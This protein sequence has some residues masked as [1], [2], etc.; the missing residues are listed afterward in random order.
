ML[1]INI[2]QNLFPS[3]HNDE[4]LLIFY[5]FIAKLS[6]ISIHVEFWLSIFGGILTI[7]HFLVL[8]RKAMKSTSII[9]L[10]ISVAICDFLSMIVSISSKDMILNF[11]GSDCTPPNSFLTFQIFWVLMSIRD[12]VVRC[13]TWLTVL[14]ALIRFLVSKYASEVR[15][16]KMSMF[17]FGFKSSA[18]SVFISSL[19]SSCFYLC[20]KFVEI[21]TWTPANC[22]TNIPLDSQ[23]PLY[24][25]RVS[26]L[27]SLYDGAPVQIFQFINGIF[28]KLI[29]CIILPLLT[30]LLVV[31]LKR[32]E[33]SRIS[34]SVL[35]KNN[36]EKTTNLVIIMTFSIFLAS[37][38]T[39]IATVF[40]V[41]YSDLGFLFIYINVD[42]ICDTLLLWNASTN[43][44]ICF[45]MSSQYRNTAK[46]LLKIKVHVNNNHLIGTPLRRT[47]T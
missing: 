42:A 12:G 28:S 14:M 30:T 10:M 23:F 22:C 13:S 17:I 25:Q 27:F 45:L 37:L 16:Q 11:Y 32:T 20:I 26:D 1:S 38:P 18:F 43:C 3:F 46:K 19:M 31:E 4:R 15:Y 9:S 47:T 8:T 7:F 39:G 35:Y 34:S 24:E 5:S 29:P 33:K 21:G 40:Q 36:T 41:I 6:R 44:F 2:T